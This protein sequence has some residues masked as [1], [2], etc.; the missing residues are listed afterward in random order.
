MSSI[1]ICA[2][3]GDWICYRH[4]DCPLTWLGIFFCLSQSAIFSGL[5][6]A[7]FSVSRLQMEADSEGGNRAAA[8]VLN[9][10]K[11]ANFLLCTIL[12]GN[13]SVNVLLALLSESVLAGLGAFIFSTENRD[14]SVSLDETVAIDDILNGITDYLANIFEPIT[15]FRWHVDAFHFLDINSW[16]VF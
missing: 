12:W 3:R 16:F 1:S 2:G 9:L 10:R 13:V 14:G 7:Y 5:N 8:K 4:H 6:L 11:N 15:N